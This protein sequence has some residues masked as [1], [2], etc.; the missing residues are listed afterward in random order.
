MEKK[1][2]YHELSNFVWKCN[3]TVLQCDI[4]NTVPWSLCTSTKPRIRIVLL[5]ILFCF[6]FCLDGLLFLLQAVYTARYHQRRTLTRSR[7]GECWLAGWPI[8]ERRKHCCAVPQVPPLPLQR[9]LLLR[10]RS[11]L[12]KQLAIANPPPLSRVIDL[13]TRGAAFRLQLALI[14]PPLPPPSQPP[15]LIACKSPWLL[16]TVYVLV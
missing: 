11:P 7:N 3:L 9:P 14:D 4:I 15:V 12:V 13:L 6:M 16:L 1:T 8:V 10:R 5:P 2:N